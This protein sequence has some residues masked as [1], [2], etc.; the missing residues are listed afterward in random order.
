MNSINHDITQIQLATFSVG[1]KSF[2]IDIMRI[3]EILVPRTLS[4]LPRASDL[5]EGVITLR[6]SVIPVMNMRRRLGM[7]VE[8]LSDH[9][10]LLIV[11]LTGQLLA[12]Q[13]DEVREV[14]TVPVGDILPPLQSL[15]G[16][17]MEFI[18]GVCIASESVC[19]V[20]DI[21]SLF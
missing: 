10:R 9:G 20:L 18:L 1:D 12:L 2:A 15:S 5:L 6:G 8:P 11:M 21:D 14:I 3:R 19:M 16:V 7:T 17:G 4:P 13:V